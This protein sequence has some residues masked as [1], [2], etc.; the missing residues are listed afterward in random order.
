MAIKPRKRDIYLWFERPRRFLSVLAAIFVV[1]FGLAYTIASQHHEYAMDR[2]IAHN[3]STANLLSV[4]VREYQRAAIGILQSYSNRPYFIDAVKKRDLDE[5]IKYLIDLKKNNP[6]ID[7][8][9]LTDA[10]GT[11]WANH[12]IF[13]K[14]HGKH[15]S[16]RDWY[17]GVSK[18]WKPYV[19]SIY[20]RLIGEKDLAVMICVPIFGQDGRVI[21]ILGASQRTVFLGDII[22]QV[23]LDPGVKA[24]LIDQAN[25]IIY[26]T[27]FPHKDEVTDYPF[28]SFI[29]KAAKEGRSNFEIKRT[30]ESLSNS[31]VA[32]AEVKGIGW[33]V[34]IDIDKE[35]LLRSEYGYFVSV[36]VIGLL[37][38]LLIAVSLVYLR[39]DLNVRKEAQEALQKD[40][41]QA[42]QLAQENSIMAE[43]GQVISSTLNIEEVYLSFSARVKILLP[44]DRIAINL[45]D[46]DGVTLINRYVEGDPASQRN[47]GDVFPLAGTLTEMMIQDRKGFIVDCRDEEE[48]AAKYPGLLPEFKAGFRSF[49]SVPLISGDKVI[50]GLHLRSKRFGFYSEKDLNLADS[51]ANQIA[52]AIANAQLFAELR[53]AEGSLKQSEE[54]AR[55]LAEENAI[56]AEIGR[57]IG[58]TLDIDEVY[59]NFVGKVKR[60]I[61]FDRI[62]INIIDT[63][64]NT[65]RNVYI[66]G[67]EVFDRDVNATY[68]LEGSGNGEIVRTKSTFLMQTEDFSEFRDRLP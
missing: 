35:N 66:A 36:A 56:M 10:N 57:I 58:S 41:E 12:P 49:L 47:A 16:Y 30:R 4:I 9:I 67:E 51:I 31:L 34:I 45:I 2:T 8:T 65:A 25:H 11:L 59:E 22:R 20:K 39:K 19:S 68:P 38:F 40:E 62:L 52:G 42:K 15:F 60:I 44:Y 64:K 7:M 32:F 26:S 46:R 53:Q 54:N 13:R 21:G 24:T 14:S 61:P 3:M 33:S 63:E 5:V 17:Q 27:R 55:Q 1:L 23:S 37:L 18:E 6:E 28:P 48:M 50:G 29:K 43:I